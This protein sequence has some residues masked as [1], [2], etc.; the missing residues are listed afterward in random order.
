MPNSPLPSFAELQDR[1]GLPPGSSWG[2]FGADDQVGTL[3]IIRPEDIVN[4]AR[5]V[6]KGSVFALN[7]R[8]DYPS[9]SLGRG[10]YKHKLI[11]AGGKVGRDDLLDSFYLQGSSQWDGLRHVRHP[12]HG[13]YNGANNEDVDSPESNH[14]GIHVWAERGIAARG[15]LLDVARYAASIGQPFHPGE[16]FGMD[17]DLLRATA[18]HQK[19]QFQPGDVL[20]IRSGWITWYEGLTEAQRADVVPGGEGSKIAG[21]GLKASHAM[22]EFLWD[23]HFAAVGGDMWA[24]EATPF[25]KIRESLHT[26]ILPLWGMPIGEMWAVDRLAE[27]CAQDGVYEFLFTSAPLNIPGGVGSPVNALALK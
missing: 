25:G 24:L 19:V 7:W 18:A 9:P 12:D 1:E 21:C 11:G 4:A 5:L 2:L 6:K 27:D 3:Q 8:Q 14:L 17:A 15:V 16:G 22:L 10:N 26:T 23:Q 13:F 20:V